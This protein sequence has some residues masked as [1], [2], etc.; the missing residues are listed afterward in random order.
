M[1]GLPT[2]TV[3]GFAVDP[4]NP[5]L[6]YVATREGLFRSDNAGKAWKPAP[7][8]PK[9]VAAVTV[10]PT[11]PQEVYAATTEGKLY[12]STDGGNQWGEALKVAGK[13][14]R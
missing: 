2:T 11:K 9:N 1:G 4:T 14:P 8:G 12:R 6:M 10:N 7:D 13:A 5:K 3:N